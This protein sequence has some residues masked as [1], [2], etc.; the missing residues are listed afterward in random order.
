MT[1]KA[2]VTRSNMCMPSKKLHSECD[3]TV[4]LWRSSGQIDMPG[5]GTRSVERCPCKVCKHPPVE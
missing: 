5:K 2:S 3:G 4:I 1:T